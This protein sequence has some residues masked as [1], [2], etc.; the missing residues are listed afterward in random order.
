MSANSTATFWVRTCLSGSSF[1]D[2]CS[3]T[4][5]EKYRARLVRSRSMPAWLIKSALERRTA[6]ASVMA[7]IRNTVISWKRAPMPIAVGSMMSN[8]LTS[9]PIAARMRSASSPWV[10]GC[11]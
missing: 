2:N 6:S 9:E 4:L 10:S 11:K 7:T 3:T 8:I 1:P 5:G